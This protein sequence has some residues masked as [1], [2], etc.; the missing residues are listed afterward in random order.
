M[1]LGEGKRKESLPFVCRLPAAALELQRAIRSLARRLARAS[2]RLAIFLLLCVGSL[3]HKSPRLELGCWW[4]AVGWLASPRSQLPA[5]ATITHTETSFAA[6]LAAGARCSGQE[7]RAP[8]ASWG[9]RIGSQSSGSTGLLPQ[10]DRQEAPPRSPTSQMSSVRPSH[11]RCGRSL[12]VRRDPLAWPGRL[13]EGGR[14]RGA[15]PKAK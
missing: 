6:N 14:L 5:R 1:R 3:K 11:A 9:R 13:K 8:A 12:C 4:L 10:T 15:P 7:F 2:R